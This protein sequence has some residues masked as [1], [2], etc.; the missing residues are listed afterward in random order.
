[1]MRTRTRTRRKQYSVAIFLLLLLGGGKVKD[2]GE[3]GSHHNKE[4][5]GNKD[6]K[7]YGKGRRHQH[8]S[9]TI[10]VHLN[11]DVGSRCKV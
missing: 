11:M 10:Y 5:K 6:G 7:D 1:M 3:R 4:N 8:S 2:R 9:M